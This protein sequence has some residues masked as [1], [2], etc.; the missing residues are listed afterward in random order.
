MLLTILTVFWLAC[1][2]SLLTE[3]GGVTFECATH[4]WVNSQL[5]ASH[6]L[7]GDC[8]NVSCFHVVGFLCHCTF[9]V[10]THFNPIQHC[11]FMI[12]LLHILKGIAI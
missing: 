2:R 3:P 6:S 7:H 4:Y 9:V 11:H 8:H 1:K 5:E 12:P 10:S